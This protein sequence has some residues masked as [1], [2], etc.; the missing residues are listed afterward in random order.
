MVN[1]KLLI[2]FLTVLILSSCTVIEQIRMKQ[3]PEEDRLIAKEYYN[4]AL[5]ELEKNNV[6]SSLL[7]LYKAKIKNPEDKTI[8]KTYNDLINS[9]YSEITGTQEIIKKGKGLKNPVIYRIYRKKDDL[10]LP[11]KDIPVRFRF[12]N[13]VGRLTEKDITNDK[14]IAKCYI[15]KIE[16]YNN[17]VTVEASVWISDKELTSLTKSFTF[18]KKSILD[19]TIKIIIQSEGPNIKTSLTEKLGYAIKTLLESSNFYDVDTLPFYN[20]NISNIEQKDQNYIKEIGKETSANVIFLLFFNQ[21]SNLQQSPDFYMKKI[22]IKIMIFDTKNGSIY[23][24]KSI[25]KKGAGKTEEEAFHRAFQN[26]LKYITEEIKD[27]LIDVERKNEF[28]TKS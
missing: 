28:F 20:L 11:V 10:V 15:E 3:I 21:V 13:A 2:P 23:L 26:C 5:K 27:Y 25:T 7:Y 12:L 22:E 8:Q 17:S 9:L 1:I 16:E 18:Y 4:K 24:I 19:T 14:G 6:Y